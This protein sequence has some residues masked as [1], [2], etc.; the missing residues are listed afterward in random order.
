MG[1]SYGTIQKWSKLAKIYKQEKPNIHVADQLMVS[2]WSLL[3]DKRY[4]VFI[5]SSFLIT[6]QYTF[7]VGEWILDVIRY[8]QN[9]NNIT[10]QIPVLD[11]WLPSIQWPEFKRVQSL[12]K[13]L[14]YSV[15][16]SVTSYNVIAGVWYW[17]FGSAK[18]KKVVH[19]WFLF[20]IHLPQILVWYEMT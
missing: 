13:F 1:R 5:V 10:S 16:L 19:V 8:F 9:K 6:I 14:F 18:R 11:D 2:V 4:D 17:L 15:I 3:E 20:H 7:N 12:P